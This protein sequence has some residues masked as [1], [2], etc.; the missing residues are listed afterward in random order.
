MSKSKVFFIIAISAITLMGCS[1]SNEGTFL[2]G[3]IK[4]INEKSG[5]MEIGIVGSFTVGDAESFTESYPFEKK[6]NAL[7]IRVSN[8][9][10]YEEGQKVQA[11][12]IK[13]YEED[14]WD[15]DKLEFEVEEVT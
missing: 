2:L 5:D 6:P 3:D 1:Q 8:P 15:L 12:V 10:E 9:Q 14:V 13:K 7:T 11:K 4:E